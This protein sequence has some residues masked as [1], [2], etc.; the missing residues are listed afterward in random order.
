M[1]HPEKREKP[2]N[3]NRKG[4]SDASTAGR[5]QI[6]AARIKVRKAPRQKRSKELVEAILEAAAQ[7]FAELGYA[8]ATTNK[9]AERAGVSVGSLYQYFPNKD[10]LIASLHETHH[11]GI[12]EVVG[13]ALK[14]FGD[15][16]IGLEDGLRRFLEELN[17][18]HE[19]N[20]TLTKAL[21]REVIREADV[22]T[23]SHADDE[24]AAEK[25]NLGK[26]LFNRSDVRDGDPAVMTAIMGEVISHLTRWLLH[27]APK[28]LDR[29][30]LREE[31]VQLLFRYLKK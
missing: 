31:T 26:L 24:E 17:E 8:R 25:D 9:I 5:L 20:P 30:I 7:I 21:S 6:P 13:K 1:N 19:A 11:I 18:V 14:R 15:P 12:H 2:N 28:S 27:D 29:D 3:F 4:V 22:D 10:S 23:N 16:S